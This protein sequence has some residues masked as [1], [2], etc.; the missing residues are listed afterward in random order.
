[1]ILTEEV[2]VPARK[3]LYEVA[4][5]C[6]LCDARSPSS[7][8]WQKGDY[9]TETVTIIHERRMNYSEGDGTNLEFDLCPSCF[10]QKLLPW[11]NAHGAKG[12]KK[13]YSW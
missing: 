5:V 2:E 6:D 11:L 12:R 7:R 9:E 3:E 1:M 13:D 4:I 10:Q 8:S